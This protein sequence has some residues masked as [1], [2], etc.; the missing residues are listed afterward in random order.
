[1]EVLDQVQLHFNQQS[2][3]L[4]NICM[5]F[6]MFGVALELKFSDFK[7]IYEY[8]RGIVAGL[9]SQFFVL[10]LITFLLV[11]LIKPIPSVALGMILVAACPGGNISN[12]LSL[13]AR[14]NAALSVSLTAFS[15]LLA[16]ILT[17]VNFSFWASMYLNT[18]SHL[19]AISVDLWEMVEAV[20][21]LLGIP[22]I[23]GMWM[24]HRYPKITQ[25]WNRVV[26]HLSVVIFAVFI[27]GAFAANL[28]IFVQYIHLIMF[29]VLAHNA[30]AYAAG[31]GLGK[32]FRLSLADT[33]AI[34]IET[35][36]QNSGLALVLIFSFFEGLGGMALMAGWWGIWDI[37]SGLILALL[38]SRVKEKSLSQG[39]P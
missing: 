32:A 26:R 22:L 5:G 18:S 15:T 10:P 28:D 33:K 16:V 6:V 39:R 1:M 21:L 31:Y 13:L 14:G 35:G 3:L 34:A 9:C 30:L 2:L 12:M 38:L 25:K 27:I 19:N 37:I 23:A 17:P 36:I 7:K 11:H 20:T 24:A 29:M 4:M 8:P